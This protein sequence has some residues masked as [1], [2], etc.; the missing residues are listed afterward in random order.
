MVDDFAEPIL[1]IIQAI[2]KAIKQGST[3]DKYVR[4]KKTLHQNGDRLTHFPSPL[5]KEQRFF[6]LF[7]LSILNFLY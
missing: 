6:F 7:T 1:H 3:L 5:P 2:Y 4:E